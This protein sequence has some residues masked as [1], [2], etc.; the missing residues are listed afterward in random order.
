MLS[1]HGFFFFF[2]FFYYYYYCYYYSLETVFCTHSVSKECVK[3]KTPKSW[4]PLSCA[5]SLK[6]R[7]IKP[8]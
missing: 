6:P 2:F 5:H 7:K 4:L 1:Y 3:T 8:G